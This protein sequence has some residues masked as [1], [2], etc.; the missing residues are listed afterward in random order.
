MV[1]KVK[2]TYRGESRMVSENYVKGLKGYERT[3]QIKSIF[4]GKKRPSTSFKSK[5]STWTQRFNKIYGKRLDE[6]KGGR[7]KRNIAKITGIPFKAIDEVFKKG[8]GAY[9]SAGSRPNQSPQSWAYARLYSYLLGGN[10]RKVDSEITKKY[11]VDFK[12]MKK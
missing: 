6:M 10:A 5:E 11:N 1:N 2:I 7:S 8:E 9:Y 4:E 3:K 12:S